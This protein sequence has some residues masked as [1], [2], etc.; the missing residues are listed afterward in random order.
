[1]SKKVTI[2]ESMRSKPGAVRVSVRA[3]PITIE[4]DP[5]DLVAAPAHAM[6]RS[7]ERGIRST[8]LPAAPSTIRRR[9][10]KGI[11]STR[12]WNATGELAGS[13]RAERDRTGYEITVSGDRL[14]R[15][16]LAENFEDDIAELDDMATEV[17]AAL[18]RAVD[19]AIGVGRRRR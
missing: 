19:D 15:D 7:L 1:M 5:P 12:R 16:E 11:G 2:D 18:E 4:T 13:V 17:D 9:R 10:A 6:A 8:S 14:Q 3:E